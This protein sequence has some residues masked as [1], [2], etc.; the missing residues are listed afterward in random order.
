MTAVGLAGIQAALGH[1][2]ANTTQIYAERDLEQ[3]RQIAKE[4]G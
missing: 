2:K 1:T 3:A 4:M